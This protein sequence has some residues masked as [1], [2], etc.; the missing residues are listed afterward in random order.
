MGYSYGVNKPA[1]YKEKKHGVGRLL[2]R[3]L[4]GLLKSLVITAVFAA[5][6]VAGMCAFGFQGGVYGGFP[7]VGWYAGYVSKDGPKSL[8]LTDSPDMKIFSKGLGAPAHTCDHTTDE[9]KEAGVSVSRRD[10]SVSV[11]VDGVHS[12]DDGDGKNNSSGSQTSKND[13]DDRPA[14]KLHQ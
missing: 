9:A 5:A 7:A 13:G 11:N 3:G 2:L 1:G 10:G 4:V 14:V 6:V 8:Y 12:G